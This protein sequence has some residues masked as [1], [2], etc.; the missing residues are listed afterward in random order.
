MENIYIIEIIMFILLIIL[1]AYLSGIASAYSAFDMTDLIEESKNKRI[2]NK[3]KKIKK[4]LKKQS[5][6]TRAMELALTFCELCIA[7][8]GVEVIAVPICNMYITKSEVFNKYLII[9]AVTFLVTYI[10][11]IFANLLPKHV[12]I[13]NSKLITYS[14]IDIIYILAILFSPVSYILHKTDDFFIKIFEKT[15]KEREEFTEA[16]FKI[17][18][19]INQELG[20]LDKETRSYINNIINLEKINVG[21]IMKDINKLNAIDIDSSREEVINKV[22]ENNKIYYAVYDRDINNMLGIV[23][24][25]KIFENEN[26]EIFRVEKMITPIIIVTDRKKVWSLLREM[27]KDKIKIAIIQDE[28][29]KSIGY[30]TEEEIFNYIIQNTTIKE[31]E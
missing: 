5:K 15:N 4:V 31:V 24:N 12:G 1:M 6:F 28:N 9:F 29:K 30:I 8:V 11:F 14:T 13:K 10:I 27:K 26:A 17:T 25:T 3:N 20:V 21:L 16:E 2:K 23:S 19:D 18:M 22:K 7:A